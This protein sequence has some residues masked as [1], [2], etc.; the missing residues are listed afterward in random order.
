[1]PAICSTAPG[2]VPAGTET[3]ADAERGVWCLDVQVVPEVG[4]DPGEA[5]IGL[6][7]DDHVRVAWLASGGRGWHSASGQPQ[8]RSLRKA[9]RDADG[10]L[11]LP[12]GLPGAVAGRA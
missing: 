9:G 3:S 7:A 5:R 6:G 4:A 2:W 8:R 11:V 1:M 12:G 10:D